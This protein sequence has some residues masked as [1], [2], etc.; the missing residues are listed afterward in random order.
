[1]IS[2][3]K[4]ALIAITSTLLLGLVG[5]FNHST[6]DKADWIS[7]KISNKLDLNESQEAK[8]NDVRDEVLIARKAMHKDRV[9]NFS[10]IETMIKSDKLN[11][12]DILA[13][14]KSKTDTL[15]LSAEPVIDKL[16][17]FHASLNAK[18][19]DKIAEFMNKRKEGRHGWGHH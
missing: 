3:K 11:K 19:K 17:V 18:Q 1:M 4:M 2:K 9:A 14:F 13:L 7:S 12:A 15:E 6:A 16:V 8:L 10:Q 5:C